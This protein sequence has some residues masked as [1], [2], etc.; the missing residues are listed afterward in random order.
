M[1][2]SEKIR[3]LRRARGMTQEQVAKAVSKSRPDVANA[4]RLLE[5]S[6]KILACL[7]KGEITAGHV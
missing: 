1:E 3:A 6:E 5:L 7:K 4:V 2:L